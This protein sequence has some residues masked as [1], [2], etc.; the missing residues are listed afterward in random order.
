MRIETDI[1]IT[2]SLTIYDAKMPPGKGSLDPINVILRDF[3]GAGQIIVECY[4]DAWSHW[5]GA[6]GQE[7]LR[8]FIA[9]TNEHYLATKLTSSTVRSA[10][11]REES[12]VTYIARA[13]IDAM[14]N[15]PLQ[16]SP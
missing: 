4:G 13:V 11:K 14:K 1:G 7:T 2:E 9:D 12:Y 10:K 6:I 15:Q 8:Q 5:F 16:L 3:G